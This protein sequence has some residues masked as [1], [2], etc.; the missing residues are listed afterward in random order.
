VN[1]YPYRNEHYKGTRNA[2]RIKKSE[3]EWKTRTSPAAMV[4][5][6]ENSSIHQEIRNLKE[7]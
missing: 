1:E 2:G 6:L 5:L 7:T 3:K 4:C